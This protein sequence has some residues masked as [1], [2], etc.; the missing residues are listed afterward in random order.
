MIGVYREYIAS[1]FSP[2]SERNI[3]LDYK[4]KNH[5]KTVK[6]TWNHNS[7]K[8]INNPKKQGRTRTNMS[9]TNPWNFTV[10]K[11]NSMQNNE[12]I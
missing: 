9:K 1:V 5:T 3:R 2:V 12:K 8:T 6:Q 4:T 10:R 7:K 11:S